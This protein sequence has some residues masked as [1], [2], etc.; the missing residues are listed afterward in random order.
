MS[1]TLERFG[2][3]GYRPIGGGTARER[4]CRLDFLSAAGCTIRSPQ[5]PA[6]D[7]LELWI[8]VADSEEPIRVDRAKVMWGD[9]N[10]FTVEFLDMPA[11]D[12]RRLRE[13]LWTVSL[14]EEE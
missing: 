5:P 1:A 13:N 14:L 7:V 6:S 9:W 11:A 10:G 4:T 12:Q 3:V 8:S 2:R